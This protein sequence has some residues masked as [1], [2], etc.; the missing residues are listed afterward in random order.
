MGFLK[1]FSIFFLLGTVL[2]FPVFFL[3][4][5]VDDQALLLKYDIFQ[6]LDAVRVVFQGVV[7]SPEGHNT[8]F[9]FF[10][11]PL[12]FSLY[13][14]LFVFTNANPFSFHLF[15][16][17]LF[18]VAS[19]LI[20]IFFRQFFS[21]KISFLLGGIF[22]LHPVNNELGAYIAAL[23]DTLCL[24]FGMLALIFIGREDSPRGRVV[25]PLFLLLALL[26]KEAGILFVILALG[27]AMVR[28]RVRS[29]FYSIFLVCIIYLA[30]RMNASGHEMFPFLAS[31]IIAD[32][33]PEHV[34]IAIQ[35]A[36]VFI[37]EIFIPTAQSLMPGY[38]QPT[39]EKS[40]V[41]SLLLAG[42][43]M[44]AASI[45]TWVRRYRKKYFLPYLFFLSWIPVGML[46]YLH[47][48]TLDVIFARRFLYVSEIGVLG[49]LGIVLSVI[50]L[51]QRRWVFALKALGILLLLSYIAQTI[52][53]NFLWLEV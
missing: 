48:V 15:Q 45:G 37:R 36:A 22:L 34:F 43:G 2:Y 9:G 52:K 26:S 47:L 8:L 32:S 3:G 14:L 12:T 39:F 1:S 51:K 49:V 33:S 31:P 19:Y 41:P 21:L 27:Y 4:F 28:K 50:H 5:V 42:A 29:Y 23:A 16:L 13:S 30:L 35:I 46:L 17:T 7:A 24:F 38:F 11:R 6:S 53:L 40:I 44:L 10:Y 25:V 18:I 20:F